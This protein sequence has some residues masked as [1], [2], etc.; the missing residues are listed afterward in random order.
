MSKTV[1]DFINQCRKSSSESSSDSSGDETEKVVKSNGTSLVDRDTSDSF[2]ST[3]NVL[4][5][6]L[7]KV[8]LKQSLFKIHLMKPTRSTFDNI[9]NGEDYKILRLRCK[10]DF[11]DEC[12]C[13]APWYDV[14]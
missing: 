3:P 10:F 12:H 13:Y 1:M 8:A 4:F 2:I 7:T 6:S 11:V 5:G 9:I 14:I